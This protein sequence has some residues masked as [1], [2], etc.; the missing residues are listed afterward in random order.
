MKLLILSMLATALWA[1]G[2]RIVFSKTFPG[3]NPAFVEITL[4]RNGEAIYKEDPKDERPLTFKLSEPDTATMFELADR[5]E[6]FAKPLESGLK[7]AFMGAKTF[8]YEG[9]AAP[10][11]AK[12]NYSDDL[13]AKT[14]LDWFERISET[15]RAYI[16]LERAVRFDK[17]GVHDSLLRIET[18]RNQKRLVAEQQFLPFLDRVIKSE[19]YMNMARTRANTLAE[20]IRAGK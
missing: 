8:R 2:P 9:D 6:H 14:L 13:D 3:S 15:E 19:A 20:S 17:L 4:E 10:K 12:F 7:V 11:E 5:L 1:D 16:D 18:V